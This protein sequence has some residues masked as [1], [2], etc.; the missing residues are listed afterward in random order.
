MISDKAEPEEMTSDTVA[1]WRRSGVAA[2]KWEKEWHA[3]RFPR[4]LRE[5]SLVIMPSAEELAAEAEPEPE[6]VRLEPEPEPEQ[7]LPEPEPGPEPELEPQQVQ[8]RETRRRARGR[9]R[10]PGFCA[11]L[12]PASK[13][14]EA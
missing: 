3:K 11:C 5:R 10:G 7:L 4:S 8:L 1:M 2:K 9:A 6:P 13:K 14:D 12:Q